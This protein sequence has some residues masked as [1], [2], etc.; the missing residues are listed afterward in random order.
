[1]G[2]SWSRKKEKEQNEIRTALEKLQESSDIVRARHTKLF[3]EIRSKGKTRTEQKM[4][5]VYL[6]KNAGLQNTI[7]NV[8][9]SIE[10][11]AITSQVVSTLKYGR[12]ALKKLTTKNRP[13]DVE[14]L[15]NEL[16]D[17]TLDLEDSNHAL[18]DLDMSVYDDEELE[19]ELQELCIEIDNSVPISILPSVPTTSLPVA[20]DRDDEP[21]LLT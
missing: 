9:L 13:E 20:L 21:L 2:C 1:M 18:V 11:G 19:K 16:Q 17:M 15:I 8:I 10:Q 7:Q 6:K 3:N 5:L 12:E 14:I 4:I